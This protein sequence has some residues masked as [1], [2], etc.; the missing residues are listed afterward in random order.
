MQFDQQKT[1]EIKLN[2]RY[3]NLLK[4]GLDNGVIIKDVDMPAAFGELTGV[5]ATKDIP[6]NTAIICVPQPLIISQEKC[7]L[8]SLSIVYDKHPELFDENE[9]SDAEFNILIFYLFNE[10]KKGEKSFYHPYVQAI[11]SNNTL[12]DWSKEELNYIEDPIILDEFAIVREDLKDLWNQAKEIFNE[13]VQVF[14]ETRPTDKE[15]F[16][17]A[18]QSVM[19]RCFGWSLKS[20]S[21]IPI[22]DFLNHSNK[23]CTHY[24]VHSKIEKLESDKLQAKKDGKNEQ[25]QDSDE[26]SFMQIVQEQYKIKGNKIN[27]SVLNVKQDESQFKQFVDPKQTYILQHQQYLTENQLKD[28]DNLDNISNSDKRAMINWINYEQLIQ[29][30]EVQLWD[31]GF[32]TSSDSEDNDS[33]EDVEIARNKQFETLKIRELSDWKLKFEEK[34]QQR[35][36]QKEKNQQETQ[37]E[38]QTAELTQDPDKEQSD[39]DLKGQTDSESILTICLNNEKKNLVTIKGLPPQQIQALKQR[40][41]QM[42][43]V[44]QQ[45][46]QIKQTIQE[47]RQQQDKDNQSDSS[48]E[49]KWDWLEENDKDVYFCITTTEPIRKHE[50][51]TVSYGRRTNRFLLSWYG[52]TLPENKYSSYNFRLW[53]NTDICKEKILSQKQI[54][55]TITINKLINPEEWDTGKINFNGND[56]PI[57]SI[58][59]EFRIKKN[60][61]NMDL[62]MYLRL[63][64]MLYQVQ[65]K[66]VLITIPVSV[67]YE[68]FVM[69]F[70]IQLLQ[71]YLNSYS[72][73]LAQDIKELESKIS[74]S[75]RFALHINKERKEILINQIMILLDAIIIL[76]KFKES[77]DLK[78][79]YISEIHNNV[80]YKMENLRGLKVYLKSIHEFL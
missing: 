39:G 29:N 18:A 35:N 36:Q 8:S 5:V 64:L 70:C 60:K 24:L 79:A 50:Q 73:E 11:Q 66:D 65:V 22:A 40:Q 71:H 74:F 63:Y 75:R 31:L 47:Q 33:D 67:D 80:Y 62:L 49:S 58:T 53:L 69:Q 37:M 43:E 26:D 59:K 13:F 68:V 44:Q 72:Q 4:W 23:A 38:Q 56:V 12:I 55:D 14:G 3:Q 42:L 10:K 41:Q 16:Y 48:E 34:K 57:S 25:K 15:D 76:K 45:K 28:I 52:F 30:S 21:M 27:L 78:Q 7:K 54:F 1:D 20:T 77:N 2:P 17:W 46:E 19:S 6:A 32:V 51:V 9:T 61:L